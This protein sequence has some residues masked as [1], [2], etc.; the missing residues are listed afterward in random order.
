MLDYCW[1][2][3]SLLS[4][5]QNAGGFHQGARTTQEY[6]VPNRFQ[7]VH[8]TCGQTNAPQYQPRPN[9]VS[10]GRVAAV[11]GGFFLFLLF[12]GG[13]GAAVVY[14]LIA[15]PTVTCARCPEPEPV[16]VKDAEPVKDDPADKKTKSD[17]PS[18]QF[19]KIWVDYNV[20]E[21]GRLGMRIHVK[22]SVYNL[23]NVDSQLAIYFEKADGTKLKST[24]KK[25]SSKDGQVA[26]Y[27]ALKPGYD[28]TVYKDLE[29]FMPY[30]ELKLGK[31]RHDL[32]MD[33]DVIY[34]SGELVEHLGYHDF[35]YEKS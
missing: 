33:A 15:R 7:P 21:Q 10:F 20:R 8:S 32:K 22:F 28:D 5:V 1:Q 18:A 19:E 14:K 13:A 30:E 29:V 23:K 17:Q 2:C 27:R 25:F 26:V 12:I 11:L 6:S 24:G 31:G 9:A 3:G 16:P 34:D 4:N 35:Q